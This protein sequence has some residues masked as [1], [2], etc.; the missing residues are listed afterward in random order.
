MSIKVYNN[1]D[2]IDKNRQSQL[3]AQNKP[4]QKIK[5]STAVSKSWSPERRRKTSEYMKKRWENEDYRNTIL[6]SGIGS[7]GLRGCYNN[8]C[9]DS[10][11][12]LSYILWC[13]Y[14]NVPIKRYDGSG[15]E[16]LD[17]DNTLRKY[18]PD[19]M[20][21]DSTIVEIKGLGLFY[22]KNYKRNIKKLESV[23]S[24]NLNYIILF[25]SDQILTLFYREARKVHYETKS[26]KIDSI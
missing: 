10:L 16:Y 20:I 5:N 25:S 8:I 11:Y 3:I 26:K 7:G 13:R 21:N 12:E 6:K 9:Y 14:Y 17:E 19:F 15:I 23:R 24:L 22:N 1:K 2:W 4:D 18:Y